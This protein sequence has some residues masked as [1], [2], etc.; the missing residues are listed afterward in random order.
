MQGDGDLVVS[1]GGTPVWSTGTNGFLGAR[2]DVQDDGNLVIYQGSTV[3][4]A[5]WTNGR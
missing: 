4:W 5:S 2:L 3:A 1:A